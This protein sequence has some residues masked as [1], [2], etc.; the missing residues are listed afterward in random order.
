MLEVQVAI[1]ML[2]GYAVLCKLMKAYCN[3]EEKCYTYTVNCVVGSHKVRVR[4]P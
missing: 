4:F 3:Y 1:G 2:L